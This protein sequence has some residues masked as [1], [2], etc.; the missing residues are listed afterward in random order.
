[1]PLLLIPLALLAFVLL[2][3][4]LT[5]LALWQ[6][7]R[8]GH[9]RRRAVPWAVRINAWLL[10]GSALLF[11]LSTWLMGWWIEGALLHAMAGLGAG[12]VV[13]IVGLW[14][15]PFQAEPAG[16]YYEPNR[17]LVLSLTLLVAARLVHG[18]WHATQLW[19]GDTGRAAWLAQ[20][21]GLLAVGGLL[22]GYYLAYTWGVWRRLVRVRR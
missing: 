12:V 9:A 21:G 5:P 6:R 19:H 11:V 17:W 22:L 2:W 15:T 18:V 1:M 20:Q 16:L 7:Y 8:R 4:L 13:G 10:T 14:L 3:L